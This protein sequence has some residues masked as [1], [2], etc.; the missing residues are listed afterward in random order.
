MREGW[1][2]KKLGEVCDVINGLWTGKKE[3][4]ITV[5]VI[6][7]ANFTKE[8][9]LNL[10]NIAY[11]DVEEKQFK[12]RE[13][14]YGDIII[15][16]SGGS[17][18]QPVGRPVFFYLKEKGYSFSNFTAALRIKELEDINPPFLHKALLFQY[19]QGVTRKLQSKT[20]GLHN[21]NF[22]AYLN[23]EIP[24]PPKS[25]QE[26]IVSELDEI[27]SLL[28]LK[29][30]Q[31][32][33][34]DKLAQSLFYEMFGDP[35]ENEKG[36]EV[37]KFIDVVK[38]Q[39]GFDL[40]T[41]LRVSSGNIPV[42]GSNGVLGFHNESKIDSGII[43]GR[44]GTIGEVF[45]SHTPCWPLNTSLFSVDTH[46]NNLVYLQYLLRA[47]DLKRFVEGA[48]VPTLNR[49]VFHNNLIIDCPLPLQQQFASRIEQIEDQKQ[50]VQA[51][52]EKLETLL[53]S[54]MQ[55]WFE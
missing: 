35:V 32:Q 54:R 40:P 49:N 31:L 45:V 14:Q 44:S 18:N 6:R 29:R 2:Y 17:D 46:G 9:T 10:D 19:K 21:L 48:G 20:T 12:T 52:I 27:N 55:Y 25:Q 8:C 22:K 5:G 1:T 47:Y 16:K 23:C 53:A 43:T 11:I 34:Y 28:A 37:K 51:A 38:L 42:Y 24:L 26:A 39:R 41:N 15:E 3:P 50:Q 33:K 30:E 36:W 4:F 13:L 7:N